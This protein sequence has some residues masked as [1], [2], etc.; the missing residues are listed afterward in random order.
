MV[1]IKKRWWR[2]YVKCYW[3]N[4]I[5]YE[6]IDGDDQKAYRCIYV[7]DERVDTAPLCATE[8]E[9]RMRLLELCEENGVEEDQRV[10]KPLDN[11]RDKSEWKRTLTEDN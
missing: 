8:K 11:L 7:N 4:S 1:E 3:P 5:R 9:A 6:D 10:W 2:D